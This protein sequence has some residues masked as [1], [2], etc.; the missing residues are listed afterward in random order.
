MITLRRSQE[1][2]HAD[3][4]WLNSRHTFS[5]ASYHDPKHMQ[6]GA[7][8][9]INE[10]HVSPGMGFGTH[11]HQNME[12]LSYVLDGALEHRDSMGTG[13]VIRPGDVQLMSAGRGVTHSEFNS[14]KVEPVH[15]L[16]IWIIPDQMGGAP[17]YQQIHVAPEALQGKLKL[18]ASPDGQDGA[19]TIKQDLALY[20]GKLSDGEQVVFESAHKTPRR[21]WVQVARGGVTL[22]G[23]TL[24]QGDAAAI[25]D[26]RTLTLTGRG[27]AEVL[28]FDLA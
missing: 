13:S 6:F 5:F 19:L 22:N 24:A 25:T 2:G 23:Q 8:R 17:G 26:E 10:D 11:P 1:R 9:V 18:I 3:H 28:L 16:Q 27:D 20:A 4:G 21:F 14:S 7:L 12:I 15:F